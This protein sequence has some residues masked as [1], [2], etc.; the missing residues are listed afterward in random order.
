MRFGA[1]ALLLLLP[2]TALLAGSLLAAATTEIPAGLHA[3]PLALAVRFGLAAMVAFALF[4][5]ISAGTSRAAAMVIAPILALMLVDALL[6]ASGLRLNLVES[7]A[8]S[9]F[10]WPGIMEI[11]TGRWMLVDV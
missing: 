2:V 4:F 7:A 9:I 1:G 11:F 10:E 6:S 5:A 8:T 3:Y